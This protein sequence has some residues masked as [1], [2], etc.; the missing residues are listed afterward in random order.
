MRRLSRR[1][2]AGFALALLAACASQPPA[3]PAPAAS[4]RV[5][6]ELLLAADTPVAQPEPD[7]V[8]EPPVQ[9]ADNPLPAYPPDLVDAR[10]P[11][12]SVSV[13]IVVDREG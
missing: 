4:G 3:P 9:R 11:P 13:R 5:S 2:L 8:H 12:Q 10:L 7:E 1:A 6:G